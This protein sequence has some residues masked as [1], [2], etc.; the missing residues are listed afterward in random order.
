MSTILICKRF[1]IW[2]DQALDESYKYLNFILSEFQKPIK[3]TDVAKECERD[4]IWS[5]ELLIW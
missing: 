4:S 3:T 5:V 2:T 1:L